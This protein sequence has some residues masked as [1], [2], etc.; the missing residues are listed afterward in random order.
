[1]LTIHNANDYRTLFFFSCTGYDLIS[2]DP[3]K[4]FC[5]RE[6]TI[7]E[8][9]SQVCQMGY[10]TVKVNTSDRLCLCR[11]PNNWS[12]G[13]LFG[14]YIVNIYIYIYI[15]LFYLCAHTLH[16]DVCIYMPLSQACTHITRDV[17][18]YICLF[19][20]RAHTLHRDVCI[21]MPLSHACTHITQRCVYI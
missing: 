1:M 8:I 13:V 11:E 14:Q 10:V 21:Y 7:L 3:N 16:R 20:V 2:L 17:C 12:W 5:C 15:C 4:M 18:I 19:H 9:V 6:G